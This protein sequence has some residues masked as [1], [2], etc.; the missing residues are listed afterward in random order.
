MNGWPFLYHWTDGEGLPSAEQCN[1]NSGPT[2]VM[3]GLLDG[4]SWIIG[5][6]VSLE[7]LIY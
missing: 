6:S 4:V 5:A 1:K 7:D 3:Y 2:S